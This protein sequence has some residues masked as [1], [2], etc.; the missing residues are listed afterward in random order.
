MLPF[1]IPGRD[2]ILELPFPGKGPDYASERA[3]KGLSVWPT[4][5]DTGWLVKELP[6]HTVCCSWKQGQG[7]APTPS[8]CGGGGIPLALQENKVLEG[9]FPVPSP[10][11]PQGAADLTGESLR[12]HGAGGLTSAS[13]SSLAHC[14]H[15]C[16]GFHPGGETT[17]Q[18]LPCFSTCLDGEIR[19]CLPSVFNLQQGRKREALFGLR[20][21]KP[22][23]VD[24]TQLP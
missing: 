22:C 15:Q 5:Q 23:S 1:F 8:P 10:A 20:V 17:S 21:Q 9:P 24:V 4:S 13:V 7:C 16:S 2:H 3:S 11:L 18:G 14:P 6:T 12:P 19:W